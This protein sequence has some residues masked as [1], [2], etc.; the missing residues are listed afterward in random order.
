MSRYLDGEEVRCMNIDGAACDRCGEGLVD[1][2]QG[3]SRDAGEEQQVRRVL[4]KLADDCP[5]CWI[6]TPSPPGT[7]P[8][9]PVFCVCFL[10]IKYTKSPEYQFLKNPLVPWVHTDCFDRFLHIL[11]FVQKYKSIH[12]M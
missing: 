5:V 2:R 8:R 12:T 11:I 4:A 9:V 3:Q 10:H 7:L 1:W 6:L